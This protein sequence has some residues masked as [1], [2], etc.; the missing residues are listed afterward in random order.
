MLLR[1]PGGFEVGER[2]VN[3]VSDAQSL[4]NSGLAYFKDR[5]I[6]DQLQDSVLVS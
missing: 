4:L 5:Q 2:D 3:G 6:T 1:L